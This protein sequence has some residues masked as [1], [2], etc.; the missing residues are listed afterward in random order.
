MGH[1]AVANWFNSE[2]RSDSQKIYTALSVLAQAKKQSYEQE[3]RLI[4]AEYSLFINADEVM[5]KA[6]NLDMTD[7]SEQD[8]EKDFHYYDEESIA[9]CGLED[10]ENF[11]TSYLNFIA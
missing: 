4:G 6:N 9:F 3:I 10:F 11:L 5:V 7:S 1:E 2:V 8:L